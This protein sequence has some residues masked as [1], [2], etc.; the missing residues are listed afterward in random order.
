MGR[1]PAVSPVIG[2]ILIVLLVVIIIAIFCLFLFGMLHMPEFC[3][4]LAPPLIV[5]TSVLHT[6]PSGHTQQA[7]R[8]FIENTNAIEYKNR[9]LMAEF[10]KNRKKLYAR[11]YT[12]HGTDFIPTQHFGVATIGG[13]G[14]RDDYFSPGERIEINLKDGYYGP[15][16][17]VELRVY[18][19]TS[20]MSLTPLTGNLLHWDYI[21]DWLGENFY[22]EH[23]G[24]RII[25]Q[26]QYQ[27]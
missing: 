14:C 4:K 16:D 25:S 3:D 12:L 27:A 9:D 17:L 23:R 22:S 5:V 20:D 11:I 2:V 21:Q 13:S 18:Q 10:F 24:Y 6:T 7:S 1:E 15:G 19:K 8:V 26:H